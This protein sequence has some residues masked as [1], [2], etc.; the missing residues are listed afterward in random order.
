M[1]GQSERRYSPSFQSVLHGV[2]RIRQHVPCPPKCAHL[3]RTTQRDTDVCVHWLEAASDQDVVPPEMLDHLLRRMKAIHHYE[4]SMR[5]DRFK[6]TSHGLIKKFLTVVRITLNEGIDC[7]GIFQRGPSGLSYDRID[8]VFDGEFPHPLNYLRRC[9]SVAE[10][11][12]C[13]TIDFGKG[14]SDDH[15][16]IVERAINERSVHSGLA[17][18]VVIGL[19]DY[20]KRRCRK[21]SDEVLHV[22]AGSQG[23]CGIV[24]IANVHKRGGSSGTRQ[25]G[26][27]IMDKS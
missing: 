16:L 19:V 24:R 27:K 10:P 22:F 12:A 13:E 2:L 18:V 21:L 5:I 4:I 7:I 17:S 1:G 8:V 25:H 3:L 23:R 9:H 14:T 6:R 26:V 11:Q 15:S 20:D